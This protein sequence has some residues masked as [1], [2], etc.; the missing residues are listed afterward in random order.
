MGIINS[1]NAD[2]V[3]VKALSKLL[4][5]GSSQASLPVFPRPFSPATARCNQPMASGT[6]LMPPRRDGSRQ[7]PRGWQLLV[8]LRG[9]YFFLFSIWIW[10][11]CFVLFFLLGRHMEVP[12]LGV[13]WELQLSAYATAIATATPDPG[14]IFDLYHSL[15]QHWGRPGIEP[16]SSQILVRF[17]TSWAI[18]GTPGP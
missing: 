5:P 13:E 7:H 18:M 15:Q 9:L 3:M 6:Q 4:V 1:G 12:R 10:K 16:T 11:K 14:S 8:L 17:L 2:Q